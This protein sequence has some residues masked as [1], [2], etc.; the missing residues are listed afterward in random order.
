MGAW[1]C[2]EALHEGVSEYEVSL[3]G[4]T[5]MVRNIA[6]L[7]PDS[8]LMDSKQRLLVLFIYTIIFNIPICA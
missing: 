5:A 1:A 3:A 8:D 4:L 2:K 6:K 7:Y